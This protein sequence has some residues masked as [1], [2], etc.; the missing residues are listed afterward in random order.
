MWVMV[1]VGRAPTGVG[2]GEGWEGTCVSDGEDWEG[3]CVDTC[4]LFRLSNCNREL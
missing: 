1:R 2:T 3:T 4:A